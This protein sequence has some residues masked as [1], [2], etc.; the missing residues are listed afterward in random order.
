MQIQITGGIVFID[1]ADFAR[2]FVYEWYVNSSGYAVCKNNTSQYLHTMIMG[3][4]PLGFEIDHIDGN[5]L[6]VQKTN[7]RFVT[8]RVNC[9]NSPASRKSNYGL[10]PKRGKWQVMFT[11]NYKVNTL[12]TFASL[13]EAI[14]VRDAFLAKEKVTST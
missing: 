11:R 6:N 12:G 9:L 13:K 2:C 5:R 7:L 3:V 10:Y 8:H 1:D 14:K 4:S